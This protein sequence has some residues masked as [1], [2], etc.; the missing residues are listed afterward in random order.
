MKLMAFLWAAALSFV[1]GCGND[2]STSTAQTNAASGG[3]SAL[4]APVDYLSTITKQKQVAVKKIDTVSLNQAVQL[5]QVQEGRLPKDLNE[6]VEKKYIAQIPETP[7]GTK[8][9]Y[10]ATSGTVKVVN[11]Q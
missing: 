10:D 4:T 2:S 3:G 8:L 11:A 1:T 7:Y 5:F 9:D 6:L